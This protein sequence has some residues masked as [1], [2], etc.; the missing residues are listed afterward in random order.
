MF[1]LTSCREK[2][3]IPAWCDRILWR[4]SCLRQI[5]YNTAKLRFSDHR[6]VWATFSCVINVVDEAMK[7][8]LRRILYTERRNDPY[9]ILSKTIEQAR[10]QSEEHIPPTPIAPGLPPASSDHHRWWLENGM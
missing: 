3:R 1:R 4:G 2:A 5:D 9:N 7:A 8:K 10:A 6:P